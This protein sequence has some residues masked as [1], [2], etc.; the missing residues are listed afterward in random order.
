VDGV[1]SHAIAQDAAIE[2][3][4]WHLA[5]LEC[6]ERTAVCSND[7]LIFSANHLILPVTQLALQV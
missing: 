1:V 7:R 3:A 6:K 2:A 4:L 5:N